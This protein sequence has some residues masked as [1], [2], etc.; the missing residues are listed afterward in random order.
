MTQQ[1]DS[2][3]VDCGCEGQAVGVKRP[4]PVPTAIWDPEEPDDMTPCL[5]PACVK[6][7]VEWYYRDAPFA[8]LEGLSEHQ[9]AQLKQEIAEATEK[10]LDAARRLMV[11]TIIVTA[12]GKVQY[13]E[14]EGP[15][16]Y[17]SLSVSLP[18]GNVQMVLPDGTTQR[19]EEQPRW[20][21]ERRELVKMKQQ[22]VKTVLSKLKRGAELANEAAN[23]LAQTSTGCTRRR[24]RCCEDSSSGFTSCLKSRLWGQARMWISMS[25]SPTTRATRTS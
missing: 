21:N 6:A 13:K 9:K 11:S 18:N 24:T 1:E 3:W 20:S 14:K 16:R 2:V 25:W 19:S 8:N 7:A 10:A 12:D 5:K 23:P 15:A 22:S 17:E 4:G